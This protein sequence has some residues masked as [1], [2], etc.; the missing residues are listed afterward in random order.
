MPLTLTIELSDH[1]LGHLTKA[2]EAARSAAAQMPVNEVLKAASA[3]LTNARN[4]NIPEFVADR[5]DK[6]E[7][8]I[9]MLEDEAW[10]LSAADANRVIGALAYFTNPKDIIA[11]HLPVLGFLDDAIVVELCAREL[12]HEL[13][14]YDDFCEFRQE[15][16]QRRG[17][18]P[19]A[20]GRAEWL[21]GRREDLQ[22]RMHR[23][24][25]RD[26]GSGYGE[27]SGYG[28]RS[29]LKNVWRPRYAP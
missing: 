25:E 8:L 15:E 29:Y 17:L 5:F 1:D 11:D 24:R 18:L 6:L 9:A 27:S 16:A 22:T 21:E 7:T 20:V 4:T 14:A 26:Q 13:E 12:S 23:R 28:R 19:E 2:I 3:L 10:A